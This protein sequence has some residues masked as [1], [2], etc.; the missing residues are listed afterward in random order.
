MKG[1]YGKVLDIDLENK[2]SSP[3]DIPDDIY[4]NLL[5]GK[6]LATYLLYRKNK[7]RVDAY[8][9]DNHVVVALGPAVNTKVWGSSRYGLF[10][11]SPL[12]GIYAE[13]YWAVQL[14][15]SWAAPDMMRLSYTAKHLPRPP[16]RLPIME[17]CFMMLAISGAKMSMNHRMPCKI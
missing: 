15:Y 8:S 6:G 3:E 14:L 12:T 17:W 5:G 4:K 7:P 1:V 9:P 16:W 10:T 11:R 2:T 13:S